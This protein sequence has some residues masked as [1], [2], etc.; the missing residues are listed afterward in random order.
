MR[1][2]TQDASTIDG[3]CE[4]MKNGNNGGYANAWL[5][6]DVN[7]GEI[8]RLELGLAH[9][10]F[11]RTSDGFF[12]GSNIAESLKILRRET[13]KNDVDIRDSCVARRVRWKQL[14]REH[15]GQIDVTLAQQFEADHFDSY[16]K[17]ERPG[18]RTLCGHHELDADYAPGSWAVPFNPSG[19]LDAKVVDTAM[20]K[21]MT[22]AA[23]WGSACGRR[24]DARQFLAD[25]PQFEWMDGLL[26]DLPSEP[27]VEFTAGEKD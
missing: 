1:R 2:A 18:G 6:G 9:V 14:M 10:G 20:A 22:F 16:T 8:A 7:T 13:T 21:R 11:E 17:S 24:F 3:W 12:L 23:R 26:N 25:H 15:R 27:W 19:T 4:V 5:L